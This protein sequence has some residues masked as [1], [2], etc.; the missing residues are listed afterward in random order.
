MASRSSHRYHLIRTALLSHYGL[1]VAAVDEVI[2]QVIERQLKDKR[3]SRTHKYIRTVHM[4]THTTKSRQSYF[5]DAAKDILYLNRKHLVL[6]EGVPMARQARDVRTSPRVASLTSKRPVVESNSR[7]ASTEADSLT[8][9]PGVHNSSLTM[10]PFNISTDE[11]ILLN[12][13]GQKGW[14]EQQKFTEFLIELLDC[15]NHEVKT[16]FLCLKVNILTK[17]M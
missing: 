3:H 7:L 1:P 15:W 9:R 13:S 14:V 12:F 10:Y 8:T 5:E 16:P 2:A 6:H 4:P 17:S 11:H